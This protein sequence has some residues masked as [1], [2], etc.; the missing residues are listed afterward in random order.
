MNP[1]NALNQIRCAILILGLL[2]GCSKSKPPAS[3]PFH[4]Q[5]EDFS[6]ALSLLEKIPLK[7]PC[8]SKI[9]KLR[10]DLVGEIMDLRKNPRSDPSPPGNPKR[11]KNHPEVIPFQRSFLVKEPDALTETPASWKTLE[12]SWE[13]IRKLLDENRNLSPKDRYLLVNHLAQSLLLDDLFRSYYE[14][15][16]GINHDSV[17]QLAELDRTV[18][19]C[20]DNSSCITPALSTEQQTLVSRIPMY[21]KLAAE[22]DNS[23]EESLKRKIIERFADRT[24]SDVQRYLYRGQDSAIRN[25]TDSKTVFKLALNQ[26]ALREEEADLVKTTI[27]GIW[28]SDPVSVDVNW[29]DSAPGMRL[30]KILFHI[31]EPGK[32]ANTDPHD[33]TVNL[34]PG[35]NVRSIAHEAGHIL[36]FPDH[37]YTIWDA[38]KCTYTQYTLG[39]D[40]MSDS[41]SGSVTSEE[42][43][44]LTGSTRKRGP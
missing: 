44:E 29:T 41:Q 35:T 39:N 33:L 30:F 11:I 22:L 28:K 34:Y 32:R 43:D 18:K 2:S 23:T 16:Q 20:F 40:I 26:G 38:D 4:V 42:W 24:R 27:E 36:G 17:G 1:A 10:H 21:A 31:L 5:V 15:N 8:D 37:Y 6:Q 7:E 14:V 12:T 13:G 9:F 3:T 25:E 19:A